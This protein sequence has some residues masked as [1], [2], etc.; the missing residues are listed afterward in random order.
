MAFLSVAKPEEGRGLT[1]R[2]LLGSSGTSFLGETHPLDLTLARHIY[3]NGLHLA[4][5]KRKALT[6]TSDW[7]N[8]FTK[9]ETAEI[10]PP[11]RNGTLN[12][13]LSHFNALPSLFAFPS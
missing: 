2:P 6:M 7:M 3:D 4:L 5:A 9:Q 11:A 1:D 10:W 12:V 13:Q 8:R